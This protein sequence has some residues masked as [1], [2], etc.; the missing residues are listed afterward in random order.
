M[1][2]EDGV[3]TL[4]AIDIWYDDTVHRLN[5]SER[6]R[7]LG[8]FISDDKILTIQKS[9]TY[10]I[11]NY[12]LSNHFDAD[13]IYI[14]K[15]DALQIISATYLDKAQDLYYVKRFAVEDGNNLNKVID[16]VGGDNG[17][18]LL[19]FSK[20]YRPQLKIV[21]DAKANGKEL[22]DEIINVEEFIGIKGEKAKG[23]RL[24][25]KST[26]SIVF[27]EPLPY[28]EPVDDDSEQS[29]NENDE[30]EA[31]VDQPTELTNLEEADNLPE[32]EEEKQA[33]P[34]TKKPD[35]L[36]DDGIAQMELEF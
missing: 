21:F 35:P 10:K 23:K 17:N 16:F 9:G 28:E 3:S 32:V 33:K 15:F 19:Q 25:N 36:T 24:T 20:D 18:T 4:G 22:E 26:K 27:I 5:T 11:M 31:I 13:M 14:E 34:K 6:G 30:Q 7:Y 2:R 1:K 12:D 29:D 8:A